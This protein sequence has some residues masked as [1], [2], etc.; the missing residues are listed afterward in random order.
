MIVKLEFKEA[1]NKKEQ[2]LIRWNRISR[3]N[4][5][6]HVHRFRTS[7][8]IMSVDTQETFFLVC[9]FAVTQGLLHIR[10]SPGPS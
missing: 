10:I 5:Y 3:L 2:M 7:W 8:L 4:K 1:A 6:W 9:F